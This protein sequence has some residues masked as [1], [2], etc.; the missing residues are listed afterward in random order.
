M[1][2][3]ELIETP[4]AII[5]WD[6]IN[7]AARSAFVVLGDVPSA[8]YSAA[9]KGN[10]SVLRDYYGNSFKE[11]LLIGMD[12]NKLIP[13]YSG[14]Y[15]GSTNRESV[16]RE[17]ANRESANRESVNRESADRES[18]DREKSGGSNDL[19]D[20]EELLSESVGAVK[21]RATE[22]KVQGAISVTL[23]EGVTYTDAAHIYPEDKYDELKAKIYLI[24][25]IPAY[26]QHLFYIESGR[27]QTIYKIYADGIIPVD[28]RSIGSQN[29]QIHG[30]PVDKALYDLR[31]VIKV[32]SLDSF[33]TIGSSLPVDNRIFVVDLGSFTNPRRTQL[34]DLLKDT[35]QFELLYYGFVL[36]YWPQL[37][38]DCFRDYIADEQDLQY[39]YPSLAPSQQILKSVYKHERVIADKNY[40]SMPKL[41]TLA[42]SDSFGLAITQMIAQVNGNRCMLNIRN[43][44]EYFRVSVQMPEIHAWIEHE[45]KK[46]LL[47]KKHVQAGDIPFPSGTIMRTGITF[48]ISIGKS[49]QIRYMFLNIW[50]SGRYHIKTIWNEEDELGF[51][52]ILLIM[53]KHVDPIIAEINK[54]GYYA[55]I[56]LGKLVPLSKMVL[57]YQSLNVCIFW[58]RV[59]TETTYKMVKALWEPYFRAGITKVRNVQQFDKYEFTFCK[60]IYQFDNT[61]IERIISASNNMTVNNYYS[62]LSNQQIKQKWDQNY[63]GRILRM[64]HR[65]TDIRF[66]I[67]DIREQEFQTVQTYLLGFI[68]SAMNDP[69]IKKSLEARRDYT[70]IKKLRKLREQDPELYNLKKHGSKKVYSIVCQNQRQPVI[71]TEDELKAMSAKDKEKLVQYWNFTL[72]KP[73]WYGCPTSAYPHLSFMVGVHPKHYCLPCCNKK[74]REDDESRKTKVNAICSRDHQWVEEADGNL[75]RHIMN[76]GKDIDVGRLSKLPQTSLKNLLH[77]TIFGDNNESNDSRETK[78]GGSNRNS[79]NGE[80]YLFGVAQHFPGVKN[81][82]IIYAIA[83]ALSVDVPKM[84]SDIIKVLEKISIDTLLRGSLTEYFQTTKELSFVMRELFIEWKIIPSVRLPYWPE[85]F[86]E[87]V[88]IVYGVSVVT[89]IDANG[90]GIGINLYATESVKNSMLG[91]S[92]CIV[93]MKRENNYYPMF[94]INPEVYFRRMEIKERIYAPGHPLSILIRGMIKSST[95]VSHG[96]FTLQ[97]LAEF[98]KVKGY[99]I[100][101]K[102]VNQH[103]LCY[104]ALIGPANVYVPTDYSTIV[105]DGVPIQTLP[106]GVDI[107]LNNTIKIFGEISG[108]ISSQN[109]PPI[110]IDK[111][112]YFNDS[113]IGARCRLGTVYITSGSSSDLPIEHCAYDFRD[114]NLA[115]SSREKP[116]PDP[117]TE[118]IGAALYT[119]CRYQLFVIEFVNYLDKER[120]GDIR[121]KI[122]ALVAETNFKKDLGKFRVAL[123]AIVPPADYALLQTQV[124]DFYLRGASKSSLRETI[125]GSIYEFDRTTLTYLQSLPQDRTREELFKIASTFAVEGEPSSTDFPNVYLPCEESHAGYCSGKKLILKDMREFVDVLAADIKD[126]L[127]VA[128]LLNN[129]WMDAVIDMFKFTKVSTEIIS[130]YKLE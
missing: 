13:T 46:Y 9:Q 57:S 102:Y 80:Y 75:S 116:T 100:I 2:A 130:I 127:R 42:D 87:L 107:E 53:K 71:Y 104:G 26:R 128:Y 86:I 31:E 7:A 77:D 41:L 29:T 119:N 114:V 123:K 74:L 40:R 106:E 69:E 30:L 10:S 124:S 89:F 54:L 97:L 118:G 52:E 58:K 65:T 15:D 20:I 94:I 99:K 3:N 81:I 109:I 34:I 129:I 85:L 95:L 36:K 23:P 115:I 66:E 92:H 110:T 101:C 121:E 103:N 68:H 17:S 98:C 48:A 11:K 72:E 64:S 76:Y 112:L 61:A 33:Q 79:S 24:T 88:Q 83:A 25:G 108:Y 37:T 122:Y 59:M 126:E 19:D 12:L 70:D 60:G 45:N 22:V 96:T 14:G 1:S 39:K 6:P 49:D 8:I 105:P 111:L 51:D 82:G 113:L 16:N 62:H 5:V 67:V 90:N 4:P 84:I 28:I 91:G 44:F 117:R 93:V 32:E 125:E 47:T 35:Y 43:I 50:P 73:A 78:Q 18:A 38:L 56:S 55:F 63:D 120:N 27:P 21:S